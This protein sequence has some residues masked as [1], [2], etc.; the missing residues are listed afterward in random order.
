ME[1]NEICLVKPSNNHTISEAWNDGKPLELLRKP[2][3]CQAILDFQCSESEENENN[4]ET[5][6]SPDKPVVPTTQLLSNRV[7]LLS[8]LH[9][10]KQSGNC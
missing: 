3:Q 1:T 10:A 9:I 5:R 2:M 8:N 7:Q 4:M 6:G